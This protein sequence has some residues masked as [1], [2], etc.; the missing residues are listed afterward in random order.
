MK[1]HYSND[2]ADLFVRRLLK[3]DFKYEESLDFLTYSNTDFVVI[4]NKN[5]LTNSLVIDKRDQRHIYYANIRVAQ[6]VMVL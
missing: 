1:Q 2:R 6:E 3:D 5:Y 4:I